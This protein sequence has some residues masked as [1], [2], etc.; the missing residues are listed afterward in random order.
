[1]KKIAI[2]ILAVVLIFSNSGCAPQ[3]K[4]TEVLSFKVFF[5]DRNNEKIVAESRTIKL[6]QN[7]NK[8]EKVMEE[9]IKGPKD[10]KLK[11]NI[12]P[13][14][15]ILGVEKY[16]DVAMVNLS[17]E[18]TQTNGDIQQMIALMTVTNT[19]TQ[20]EEINS[21]KILIDGEEFRSSDGQIYGEFREFSIDG[22]AANKR[23]IAL[24]FSGSNADKLIKEM[25]SIELQA[26]EKLEER[27]IRELIKGP[28][29]SDLH[30]TIPV[31]TKILWVKTE[32][33]LAVVNLSED[34]IRDHWGGSAGETM[35][36]FSIVN[37]LTELPHITKVKFLIEGK[38]REVFTHYAFHEPF[39]RDEG[40]I[41][42]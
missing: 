26:N 18:F 42:K 39:E 34:F 27:I 33:D 28:R 3:E 31:T 19:L 10:K 13:K 11:M 16:N 1:M 12:H 15:K 2:F 32:K 4:Q 7:D 41:G 6:K 30:K 25:R 40:L 35:T 29:R 9:L 36:I 8:Y 22:D 17:K 24:Y 14:T 38:E 21:V 5:A 20:F 37:S 23:S